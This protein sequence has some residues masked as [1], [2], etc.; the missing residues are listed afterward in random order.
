MP[1]PRRRRE[2]ITGR[3]VASFMSQ[4]D[5]L[6]GVGVEVFVLVPEPA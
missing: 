2:R 6:R 3:R 5:P 1:P 4:V